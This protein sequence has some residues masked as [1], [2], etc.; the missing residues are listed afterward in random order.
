MGAGDVPLLEIVTFVAVS[1]SRKAAMVDDSDLSEFSDH[2]LEEKMQRV[3]SLLS[4]GFANR[5][6]DRGDKLRISL[7]ELQ[8][9]RDRRKLVVSSKVG[10]WL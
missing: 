8:S 3:M 9:E 1:G 7:R 4:S 2:A 5:L 10:W 6:A